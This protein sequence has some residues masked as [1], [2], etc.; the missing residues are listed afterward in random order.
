MKNIIEKCKT[1]RILA[2]IGIVA[3]FL[4]II[5][6]YVSYSFLKISLWNYWEGKVMLL[7]VV[8]NLLFIYKDIVEKYIPALF[9]SSIGQKIKNC[10]NPK[11]SLIPTVLCAIFAI[12][13]TSILGISTLS[14]YGLGFYAIWIGTI[15]LVAYAFLHKQD[16]NENQMKM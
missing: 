12:Y 6:P 16:S 15:S 13:L 9:N 8:A 11:F 4:G 5:M 7:I 2:A 3:L 1:T 10:D 14:Y